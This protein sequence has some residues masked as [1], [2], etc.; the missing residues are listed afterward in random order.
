MKKIKIILFIGVCWFAIH[1]IFIIFDGP[2]DEKLHGDIAIILGNKVN[3]DGSLSKRLEKRLECGL[4]LFNQKRV[5][6]ILVSGG[7]GKEGHYEG[8]VMK[9]FLVK[10]GIADSLILVDNKGNNTELTAIN[11]KKISTQFGLNSI[12]IV[13]QYYHITRTKMLFR[14]QGFTTISSASP[15][16]FEWRDLYAIFREFIAFYIEMI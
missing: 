12:I 13:S 7:L 6:K 1:S 15:K 16:Y 5:N 11:C 2:R 10:N 3:E 4:D 9:A 14:K 8:T